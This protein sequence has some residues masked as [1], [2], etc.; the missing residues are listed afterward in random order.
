M[1]VKE[2]KEIG[3][4]GIIYSVSSFIRALS[5]FLY[6]PLYTSFLA[7]KDYGLLS[8]MTTTTTLLIGIF[9]LGINFGFFRSYFDYEND[10]DKNKLF[11]TSFL[12][13]S[14]LSISILCL[15]LVAGDY[16]SR[17][18]FK[19][20]RFAQ[21]LLLVAVISMFKLVITIP[22]Q[23]LRAEKRSVLYLT[24]TLVE[25]FV[26]L[27]LA[28]YILIYTHKGVY[29]VL[30]SQ[31]IATIVI[32]L[33]LIYLFKG[34]FV[35]SLTLK[36]LKPMF[37]FGF[38]VVLSNLNIFVFEYL[39]KYILNHYSTLHDVGIFS[40]GYKIGSVSS[41][42]LGGP[43]AMIF[44]PVFLSNATRDGLKLYRHF[45]TY[46]FMGSV[47]LFL[48]L[49]LY[50]EEVTMIVAGQEY[51]QAAK[52]I[53]IIAFANCLWTVRKIASAGVQF[54]RKTHVMTIVFFIAALIN[55]G[56]NLLLIPR[57][58]IYG[59]AFAT[60]ITTICITGFI[61]VYNAS[62]LAV[63][64]EWRRILK[65]LCL[66]LILYAPSYYIEDLSTIL[67][68]LIKIILLLLFAILLYFGKT[69]T[70]E[71]LKYLNIL[72]D[73]IMNLRPAFR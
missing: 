48:A 64:L 50:A 5:G 52:I 3:R 47:F 19:T 41:I 6:L 4:H 13:L 56:L 21:E 9:S 11:T 35:S 25:V 73:K 69:F 36:E 49:S 16:F 39:N 54:R 22:Y 37:L 71:E 18:I 63:N 34:Y 65:S 44:T 10:E 51:I 23:L 27:G 15:W 62:I 30:L 46:T 43:L 70:N 24:I 60:L 31:L 7:T 2:I 40:L 68:V 66:A 58:S 20:E 12:S 45:V 57:Y 26:G 67:T 61:L 1:L 17:L 38:P 8:L 32:F 28:A 29:G 33:I 14:L 53:P 59:A 42:L 55:T 72:K